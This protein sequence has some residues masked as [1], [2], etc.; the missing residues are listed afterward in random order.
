MNHQ[1]QY[2]KDFFG[3]TQKQK[4][5]LHSKEF[6][7]LDRENLIEEI[8]SLGK[9]EKNTME[10]HLTNLTLHLL[11]SQFQPEKQSRFWDSSIKI[12]KKHAIKTY[13]QNPSLKP[14]LKQI[15]ADAYESARLRAWDETDLDI[16]FFPEECPWTIEELL[17]E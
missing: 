2:E 3:W 11:K 15:L 8:E 6:E 9:K 7:K 13:K 10:S 4:H 1:N 12:S 17:Q 14:H 5:F 16:S